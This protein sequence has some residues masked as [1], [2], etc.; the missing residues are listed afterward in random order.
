MR[1]RRVEVVLTASGG[2]DARQFLVVV[3]SA[4]D[5]GYRTSPE[6]RQLRANQALVR[7]NGYATEAEML[8]AAVNLG[9]E[10]YVAPDRRD[11]FRQAMDTDGFVSNFVSEVY[12]HKTRERI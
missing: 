4:A 11:V 5:W 12:R 9:S 1:R 10:W 3:R 7:L 8:A 6:G 2:D